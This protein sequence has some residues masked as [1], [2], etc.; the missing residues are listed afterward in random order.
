MNSNAPRSRRPS[1]RTAL[2][3]AALA[4][5]VGGGAY[6]VIPDADGSVSA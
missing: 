4:V 6:A 1:F 3:L 5:M 2:V